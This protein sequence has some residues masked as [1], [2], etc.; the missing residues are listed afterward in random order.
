MVDYGRPTE[1]GPRHLRQVVPWNRVWRT[2]AN[3]A[4][5]LITDVPLK[6][7]GRTIPPGAYSLWSIPSASGATLIVNRRTGQW[8]TE[9]DPGQ[10]LGALAHAAGSRWPEPVEQFTIAIEPATAAACCG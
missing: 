6:I 10:D 9:Y 4:T 1:A 3:A 5:Q 2:G 7:D 8:G